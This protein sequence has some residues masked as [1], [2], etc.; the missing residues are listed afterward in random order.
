MY[1]SAAEAELEP[2]SPNSEASHGMMPPFPQP[3]MPLHTQ[4]TCQRKIQHQWQF[5]SKENRSPLVIVLG[6]KLG[7]EGFPTVWLSRERSPRWSA[8]PACVRA[9]RQQALHSPR[10]KLSHQN[11]HV[12]PLSSWGGRVWV[13]RLEISMF[14][15]NL[16]ENF[17]EIQRCDYF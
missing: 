8:G 11:P 4:G 12:Q 14:S 13:P 9:S 17:V 2:G 6:Q 10:L 7:V 3:R 15:F 16:K 5:T 1:K